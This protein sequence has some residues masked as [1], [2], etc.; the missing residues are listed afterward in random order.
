MVRRKLKAL[1]MSALC[2][3]L[4]SVVARAQNT[5]WDKYTRSG[6]EAAER[7]NYDEAERNYL[8][9]IREAEKLGPN[10]LYLS[11]SLSELGRVNYEQGKYAQAE[12]LYKRAL[13][14][15]EELQGAEHPG[16]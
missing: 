6:T 3:F 12:A 16:V 9:A 14:I 4:L 7:G 1:V 15:D 11:H 2:L 8:A 10:N 13:K 5:L